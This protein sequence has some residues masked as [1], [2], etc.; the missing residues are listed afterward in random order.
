MTY[1]RA[2]FVTIYAVIGIGMCEVA[3]YFLFPDLWEPTHTRLG[4]WFDHSYF[5]A[6]GV[7]VAAW[8]TKHDHR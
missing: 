7:F 1:S 4:T 6:M 8:S 3:C 2:M 5:M